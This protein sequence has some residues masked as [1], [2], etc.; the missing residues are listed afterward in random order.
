MSG[1]RAD[2]SIVIDTKLDNT[3]FTRGSEE[4]KHAVKSLSD[5]V[6]TTGSKLQ[7]AFKFDFGQP[8]QIVNSFSRV[9]KQINSEM[10]GLGE[11]GK[12]AIEGDEEALA[13]FRQESSTT[14]GKLEEMKT[15]L[16]KFGQTSFETAE[17]QKSSAQYK[18]AMTQVETLSKSLDQAEAKFESLTNEFGKSSELTALEDKLNGLK[19]YKA[20]YDEAAKNG[21]SAAKARA[22]VGSGVTKGSIG[23]AIKS[24]EVELQRLWDKFEDSAPYKSAQKEI[25]TIT[26]KLHEAEQAASRYKAQL[27]S[28]PASFEGY[29][30]TEYERDQQSLQGAIDK[31][32]EYRRLVRTSVGNPTAPSAE[33]DSVQEKWQ[34]MATLSGTIKNS[35][36]N[37]FGQIASSARTAGAAISTGFQHPVQLLDRA[38]GGVASGAGRAVSALGGLV[39]SGISSGINRIADAAKRAAGNLV[40]M[41]KNAVIGAFR[42]LGGAISGIG[43]H[44]GTTNVSLA[45]G[46]KT[47]LKYGIGIR[48]LFVL[49]NRLRSALMTG[50]SNLAAY[51]T[52]FASIV[53]NF[54]ASLATLQN[55]FAA[56]FAPIAE[57]ALPLLSSLMNALSAAISQIGQLIAALTGKSSFKR[58]IVTQAG[59]A[60]GAGSAANAMG[61][62]AKAAKDV[63]KTLAG[64]DDVEILS[65]NS[66]K[67]TKMSTPPGV[68]EGGGLGNGFEDMPIDGRFA[69]LAKKIKDAWKNADFTE[70]GRM[71]GEKLRDALEKI[72]WGKIKKTLRKIAK[73]IA[74]FLNGFLETPGLF[75]VIGKTLAEAI[76]SAFEFVDSFVQNFHWDSLGKAIRDL[77]L[78]VVRNIDWPLIYR[79]AA[80]LGA[81]IGKAVQSA[82]GDPVIWEETA[83]AFSKGLNTVMLAINKFLTAIDWK[84][85][86][87]NIGRG[88]NAGIEAFDWNLLSDTLVRLINGAFDVW[89][90]FVTTFD[91]RKF[92][93]H[94]GTTLSSTI[95]GINWTEGGASVA[96]SIN[97]LFRAL[98]GFIRSTDW[99]AL[100]KAVVDAIGGFFGN[101]DWGIIGEDLSGAIKAL[102]Q[103]WAGCFENIDWSALPGKIVQ[104]IGDFLTHFDWSGVAKAAGEALG[105]AFKALVEVGSGLWEILKGVGRS[106]VEGG[107]SGMIDAM[108]DIGAWIQ[109]HIFDPFIDGIKTAFGMEPSAKEMKPLG[110]SII[111]GLLQG[112][113]DKLVD[114]VPWAQEFMANPIIEG[115]RIAFGIGSKD[116]AFYGT[117]GSLMDALRAGIDDTKDRPTSAAVSTQA[118]MLGVFSSKKQDWF[119]AGS[120]LLSLGLKSGFLTGAPPVVSLIGTIEGQ[121]RD[122]LTKNKD[123]W[124]EQARALLTRFKEGLDSQKNNLMTKAEQLIS[125]MRSK[126]DAVGQKMSN[127]GQGIMANLQKGISQS[128]GSISSAMGSIARSVQSSFQNQNW[129]GIGD[130]AGMGIYNGLVAHSSSLASLAWNMASNM[131]HSA[132]RALGIASPSK[133]FTWIGTMVTAGFGKG[134]TKTQDTAVNA[135]TTLANAVTE[136]AEGSHPLIPIGVSIE[137]AMNGIDD[138]LNGFSDK[139]VQSFDSMITAMERIA[140]GPSFAMPVVAQGATVPYAVQK[141]TVKGEDDR[142]TQALERI[143][144]Q[145]SMS[146]TRKDLIEVLIDVCRRYLNIDFYIGDEQIARHANAGNARLDRRYN[147]IK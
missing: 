128:E 54:K 111:E 90:K 79:T 41:A 34:N 20:K 118:S 40:G 110:S 96:E 136:E 81:G 17:H 63:Q 9:I 86:G 76:N 114:I 108:A 31:L 72:P 119:T 11:L 85:M 77:I 39:K 69:D 146:I 1:S 97:G 65:D 132:C 52:G 98:G 93:D 46:F 103:Y 101:L 57:I 143:V 23:D 10:L 42:K 55:S 3:G 6:N 130:Y 36:S 129:R 68:T 124:F 120:D 21:D 67:Q 99:K 15:E 116:S 73:S 123:S 51:D 137:G 56:A 141:S 24:A 26:A 127:T 109:E 142:I 125:G 71:V 22:M 64:F 113:I 18:K 115:V 105:A 75:T 139:V 78:G 48:S 82:L 47:M 4:L 33:W 58:A 87:T 45:G 147:P 134:V 53:N 43:R 74:T 14:L 38:L 2:G 106:I 5:Q 84:A 80:G 44:A 35:F 122:A 117:G 140:Q 62:E 59:V 66:S 30:T 25:D 13:R 91:F 50:F 133:V 70:I 7:N 89:Y 112:I 94:I 19:S 61:D 60:K 126:M 8:K 83:E 144:T 29:D 92:G 28:S 121:I 12:R 27:D 32:L 135:V 95:K 88:F 37:A 49:F 16:D 102:Y 104:A 107:F 100:G 138:V 131:Y 145:A